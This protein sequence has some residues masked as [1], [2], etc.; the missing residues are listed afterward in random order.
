M[1]GAPNKSKA[2]WVFFTATA[3]H[4]E[5]NDSFL[6]RSFSITGLAEMSEA[7]RESLNNFKTFHICIYMMMMM[8]MM[9]M[10]GSLCVGCVAAA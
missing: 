9:Y 8:M 6:G 7:V 10:G 5:H 2:F 1:V 4:L 3:G